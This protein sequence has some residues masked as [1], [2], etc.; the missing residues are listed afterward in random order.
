[1]RL[2]RTVALLLA[3]GLGTAGCD[4]AAG[5]TPT[6]APSPTPDL[7]RPT[8]DAGSDGLTVRYRDG[9]GHLKTLRV[10]DFRH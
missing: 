3:A 4:A 5:T 6:P 7:T 2:L 1:M 10:E 9:D 8:L